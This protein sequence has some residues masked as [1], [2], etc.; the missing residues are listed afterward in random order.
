MATYEC[1]P[2]FQREF[3]R[4]SL[5][6]M[7]AFREAARTMAAALNAGEPF[8]ARLRVK[9]VNKSDRDL[10]EVTFAPNGRAFFSRDAASP[11]GA[12]EPHVRWERVGGH[13]LFGVRR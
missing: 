7:K 1:T 9:K 10:W 8:P 13:D 6:D 4:L 5:A 12:N 3:A 11:R 2:R